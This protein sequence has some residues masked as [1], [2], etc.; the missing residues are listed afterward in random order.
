MIVIIELDLDEVE[1]QIVGELCCPTFAT[2][3]DGRAVITTKIHGPNLNEGN[4]APL[5]VDDVGC[6]TVT[7]Y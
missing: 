7:V 3:F 1:H 2:N 5:N 4:F 6:I